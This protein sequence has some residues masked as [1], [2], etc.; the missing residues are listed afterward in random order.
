[1]K[2]E[3]LLLTK[4][5][6]IVDDMSSLRTEL[7]G[8]LESMGFKAI[9]EKP[10]GKEA[11]YEAIDKANNHLPYE[12]IFSDINMPNMNGL[13]LLKS[14]RAT[15]VYKKTPIFLVSTEQEKGIIMKAI[16]EGASDYII[17]PY[18]STTV[19]LKIYE[20]LSKHLKA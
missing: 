13:Q 5:V 9:T 7:R 2:L 19:V 3:E 15:D 6:L 8:I 12:I 18:E 4:R 16:I 11:L 17:K 14:L 1:M 10:D 20:Y